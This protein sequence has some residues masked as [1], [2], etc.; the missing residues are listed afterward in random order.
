M[1]TA[2][3]ER[4][5]GCNKCQSPSHNGKHRGLYFLGLDLQS[6]GGQAALIS[7]Y[8]HVTGREMPPSNIGR[9]TGRRKIYEPPKGAELG[10]AWS[11]ILSKQTH[12][13]C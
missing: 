7:A 10:G 6:R 12:S 5:W 2:F 1:L 11:L 4:R 8:S 13:N 9:P 3:G